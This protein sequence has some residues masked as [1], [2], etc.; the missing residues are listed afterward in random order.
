MLYPPESLS[1]KQ[2]YENSL[3]SHLI[4]VNTQLSVCLVS[5]AKPDTKSIMKVSQK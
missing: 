3:A 1:R 4:L 2:N 5:Y